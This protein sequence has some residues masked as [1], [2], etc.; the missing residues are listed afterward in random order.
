MTLAEMV[1]SAW[2]AWTPVHGEPEV[3]PPSSR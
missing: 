1:D 2:Q 3:P